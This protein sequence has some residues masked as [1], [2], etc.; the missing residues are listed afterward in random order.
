[1]AEV[2]LNEFRATLRL[3][4]ADPEGRAEKIF[5]YWNNEGATH[6]SCDRQEVLHI[7]RM[8]DGRFYLEIANTVR[9]GTLE[10]L[11]QELFGWARD[12]GWLDS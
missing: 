4:W 7:M 8:A 12:E 9:E 2:T 3:T 1:M 5:S 6:E 11:E 10:Q